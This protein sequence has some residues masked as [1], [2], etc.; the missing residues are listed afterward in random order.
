MNKCI[1]ILNVFTQCWCWIL[2]GVSLQP[3]QLIVASLR[4]WFWDLSSFSAYMKDVV[5][6][7]D[8]HKVQSHL[9]WRCT[10][11]CQLLDILWIRQGMLTRTEVAWFGSHANTKKLRDHELSVR[12]GPEKIISVKVVWDLCVHLYEELSMKADFAK[13]SSACYCHLHRLRQ[14]RH[15]VR[16]S[17]NTAGA[18]TCNEARLL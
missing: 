11:V 4:Y 14:I 2:L 13:V 1:L 5:D 18:C 3:N 15:R 17:H 9:C 16:A 7:L 6:L 10:A 12:V 8:W